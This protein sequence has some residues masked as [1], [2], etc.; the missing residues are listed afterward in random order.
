[1]NRAE[2]IKELDKA[3]TSLTSQFNAY[4]GS[5]GKSMKKDIQSLLQSIGCSENVIYAI[6]NVSFGRRN[7]L[8][9]AIGMQE[10]GSEHGYREGIRMFIDILGQERAR[11]LQALLDEDRDRNF[12]MQIRNYKM[13]LWTLVFSVVAA[14]VAV[15]SLL[16]GIFR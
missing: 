15:A 10:G 11:L 6:E 4:D 2:A 7:D 3:I 12:R 5:N 1:M 8:S 16:V 13:Q 14:V 9:L